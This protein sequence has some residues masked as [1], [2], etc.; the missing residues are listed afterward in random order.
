MT[1]QKRTYKEKKAIKEL[2]GNFSGFSHRRHRKGKRR[3]KN[4]KQIKIT[5]IKNKEFNE[6]IKNI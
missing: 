1:A 5:Q 3:K 4:T 2:D 6:D